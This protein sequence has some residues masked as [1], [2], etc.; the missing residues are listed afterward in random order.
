MKEMKKG[1]EDYYDENIFLCW[2]C[3]KWFISLYYTIG[4]NMFYP[5]PYE[6][7]KQFDSYLLDQIEHG[8]R[9]ACNFCYQKQDKLHQCKK[10][11]KWEI[12]Y[13]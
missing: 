7:D 8:H 4:G 1:G 5:F 10:H 13:F 11:D 2:K 3:N 9:W 6:G 12:I